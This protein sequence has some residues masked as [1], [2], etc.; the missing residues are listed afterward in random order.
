MSV[1]ESCGPRKCAPPDCASGRRRTGEWVPRGRYPGQIPVIASAAKQ[2]SAL[3]LA[4]GQRTAKA[5]GCFAA[6]AMTDGTVSGSFA[7]SL[8]GSTR[9]Q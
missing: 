3:A 1:P 7:R 5:L 6:L 8:T 9:S 2:P 4:P